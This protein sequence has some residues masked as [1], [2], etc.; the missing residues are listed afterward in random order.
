MLEL[1]CEKLNIRKYNGGVC[2]KLKFYSCVVM[3]ELGEK[4]CEKKYAKDA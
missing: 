4:I 3:W 2:L 1:I